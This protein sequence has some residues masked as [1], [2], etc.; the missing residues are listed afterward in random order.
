MDLL[1]LLHYA[2][3]QNALSASCAVAA[4]SATIGY[5]LIGRGL[6]F[7]GHALPN[8]GFAGAAGAV[9]LGVSP[10]F[11]L[12]SF[13]V[14]AALVFAFLGNEVHD[15]DLGIGI[16]MTF[17][18]GLGLFFLALYS[19]YAER[20]YGILFGTILGISDAEVRLTLIS[21]IITLAGVA[22]IFRP[23][24]FSTADAGS[25]LA[26]GVPIHFVATV[27]LVLTAVTVSLAV[28][29]TGSLLVFTLLVGP[30]ATARVFSR[31][32]AVAIGL[33]VILAEAYVVVGILLAVVTKTIPVSFFVAA[34]SFG[35][36][37]IS[38]FL[39][40]GK[41]WKR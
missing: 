23:L 17:C 4:C 9:L 16:V 41:I 26:R 8:I 36:Y 40:K 35:V 5:F 27:F 32:P 30:A 7:A 1:A 20:V 24:L 3:L 14:G 13:T 29:V 11:G 2:F 6:T 19:G 37:L 39:Q 15:R 12:F 28:Q 18:L 21:S 34:L 31:R 38:R 33:A 10:V 25:A 22:V